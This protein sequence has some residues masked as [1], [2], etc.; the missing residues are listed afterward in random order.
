LSVTHKNFLYYFL[1]IL[2][3]SW[4]WLIGFVFLAEFP[5]FAKDFLH[6]NSHVFV[7]FLAIFSLGIGMGAAICNRLLKGQIE[8]T[9]VPLAALVLSLFIFD[10]YLAIGLE[11]PVMHA[12]PLL[13]LEQFLSSLNHWRILGDLLMIA[14]SAGIYIVPLYTILQ[15]RSESTHKARVIACNNIMNALFMTVGAIVVMGL[16]KLKLTFAHIFLAT[17]CI[18][19]LV[20]VKS[21]RLLPGALIKSLLRMF[22]HLIYKVEVKGLENFPADERVVIVPNHTSFLDG[23]LIAAFLP[24]KVSFAMYGGFMKKWWVK[25]LSPFVEIFGLEP[26]NPYVV[27]HLVKLV[28]ENKKLVI[29]PEGRITVTGSLMKIYEGPG[30]IADK[31]D[32]KLLPILI[33]GAQYTA[34]SRLKGRLPLRWFPKVTLTLFPAQKMALPKTVLGK[35]R[36]QMIGDKLY[37]L[38]SHSSFL[39]T[40]VNSGLFQTLLDAKKIYGANHRVVEDIKREPLTYQQFVI[41]SIV[42]GKKLTKWARKDEAVGILLPNMV[43]TALTFFGLQAFSRVAALLNFST[44]IKNVVL[45]CQT[46]KIQVVCTSRAFIETA[47][48]QPMIAALEEQ[49]IK[50]LYLEDIKQS[51]SIFDK[52]YGFFAARFPSLFKLCS[53][54]DPANRPAVILFTSGSEGTP[55]AV[56]LSSK[57]IHANQGQLASRVDFNPSDIVLNALPMFHSFGLTVGTLLPILYGMKVFLYPSPLHY[58]IVPELAYEINATI[59]FGTNTFLTGYARYAHPY[60]FYSVR[61]VYAG[62]EKLKEETRRLWADKFGIRVFEGYGATEASPVIAANTPMHHRSSSVGKL[63]PG[64]NYK[65]DP[66]PGVSEGGRLWIHGPNVMLGYMLHNNPGV[67]VPLHEGWYDTGDIVTID[68]EGYVF[69]QG[70]AK[71]FAKIGGE[72]I[73]LTFVEQYLDKLWPE[74]MH[75]VITRSDEKKGE[76]LVLITTKSPAMK[77]EILQYARSHGISELAVP[78]IIRHVPKLPVLGSGKIDYSALTVGEKE[79]VCYA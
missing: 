24:E 38:M 48:L 50:L 77:N 8:A 53:K 57:N 69:I 27:K 13:T 18:N 31:A 49:Q 63:M 72:M 68:N 36:R 71:R 14:I 45:A 47:K 51:V 29:F 55:K 32:A 15:H 43:A 2:G 22:L 70:R 26:T 16:L 34:F 33:E 40:N 9:F 56:V 37:Q 73:S 35:Q 42:L 60:D 54:T 76:Q 79:D 58:R 61:Y 19:L 52:L 41:G 10:L 39:G 23:L 17:A 1:S 64:M 11:K 74:A 28:K 3:I 20:V 30:L 25:F 67:L 66:V 12:L 44:G 6:A 65:L 75:A 4:F 7:L 46:A 62:A 21:C 59:L 78:K 5:N